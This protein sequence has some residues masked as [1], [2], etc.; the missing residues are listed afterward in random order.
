M[1]FFR[2]N[3]LPAK[4]TVYPDRPSPDSLFEALSQI[5]FA[6]VAMDKIVRNA[7]NLRRDESAKVSLRTEY[8]THNGIERYGFEMQLSPKRKAVIQLWEQD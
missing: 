1:R 6:G 3:K 8:N 2:K 5:Q 4:I 7:V